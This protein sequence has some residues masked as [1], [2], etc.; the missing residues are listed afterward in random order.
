[1][2]KQNKT[3]VVYQESYNKGSIINKSEVKRLIEENFDKIVM[4]IKQR[5]KY[6]DDTEGIVVEIRY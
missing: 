2:A 6:S 3:K 1:M 5:T 4:E